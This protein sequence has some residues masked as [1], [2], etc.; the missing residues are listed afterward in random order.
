MVDANSNDLLQAF[1]FSYL[2]IAAQAALLIATLIPGI[3][4]INKK[5]DE[6]INSHI[7][8]K[9][10]PVV[11][12]LCKEIGEIKQGLKEYQTTRAA[13]QKVFE[14]KTDASIKYLDRILMQMQGLKEDKEIAQYR[15][16]NKEDEEQGKQ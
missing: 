5:L 9:I 11:D 8:E 2:G 4:Y 16:D 1:L 12:N 10:R 14:T 13:L 3:K 7:N 15:E 6:R